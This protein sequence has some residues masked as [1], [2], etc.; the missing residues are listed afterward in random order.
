[1]HFAVRSIKPFPHLLIIHEKR[2]RRILDVAVLNNAEVI[3]L[4][5]FG[6][7]AFLNDPE[8]VAEAAKNVLADY[9]HAFQVIELYHRK[10]PGMYYLLQLFAK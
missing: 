6:C 5:A 2:L 4:G 10:S 7:G 3:V 1:M 9:L 8:I